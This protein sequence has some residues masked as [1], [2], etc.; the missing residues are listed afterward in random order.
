MTVSQSIYKK[1]G[2]AEADPTAL[3]QQANPAKDQ[4]PDFEPGIV[5]IDKP[6]GPSSFKMVYLVRRASGIK[7]VGHTGTLDPFA[8]GLLVI[9]VGRPATRIISSLMPGTKEYEVCA[10]LGIETDTM[11]LEGRI[12]GTRPV[13]EI[14]VDQM[15]NCLASFVGEQLQTPPQFSALKHKGKPLYYYARKGIEIKKEARRIM[16]HDIRLISLEKERAYFRVTCGKGTYI[17]SLVADLGTALGC[18]AHVEELR[19]LRNGQ[20]S[21]KDALLGNRIT[22]DNQ[23]AELLR[24]HLLPVEGVLSQLNAQEKH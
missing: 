1:D 8:S 21:V 12:I 18:G 15:E 13:G 9:C 24:S 22:P 14:S 2:L 11:D 16:I 19:R 3:H 10:R 17:R 23:G 6:V 4:N 7:K 20:F 5:L